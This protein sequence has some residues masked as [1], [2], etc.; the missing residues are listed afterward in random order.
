M[1]KELTDEEFKKWMKDICIHCGHER[2]WH[3]TFTGP[4]VYDV[5]TLECDNHCKRFRKK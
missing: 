2:E 3:E 5:T 4:C 1:K